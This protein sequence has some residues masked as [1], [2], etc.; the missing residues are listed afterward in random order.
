MLT[1]FRKVT[2]NKHKILAVLDTDSIAVTAKQMWQKK[3]GC[4]LINNKEGKLIGIV[5]ERDIVRALAAGMDIEKTPVAD[6]MTKQVISYPPDTNPRKARE[7]M[8]ANHIRHL[9]IADGDIAM[10]MFSIRDVTQ[11]QILED[12]LAAEKVLMMS[13][14]LKSIDME[15]VIENITTEVPKLFGAQRCVLYLSL[16]PSALKT[17]PFVS[18]KI[19]PCPHEHLEKQI[20][21]P[22]SAD[23]GV[24]LQSDTPQNCR[25]TGAKCPRLLIPL[26]IAGEKKSKN[27][28]GPHQGYLC[29]CSLDVLQAANTDV[30][31]YKVKLVKETLIAHLTNA[32]Q[33]HNARTASLV[34]ELTK[35]GSRKFFEDKLHDECIRAQRYNRP[36]STAIID[37]DNFK[38]INDTL[39]HA[40][41]DE[42]LKK[43]ADCMNKNKRTIDIM[44]RYGGD[45][46][47]IIMPE[48]T[49]SDA[50]KVMERLRT[51]V[52]QIENNNHITIS[53]GIAERLPQDEDSGRQLMQRADLTL[54]EA[55]RAGRNCVKIW[56]KTMPN[57]QNPNNIETRECRQLQGSA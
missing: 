24:F 1:K 55:K 17:G 21:K 9:P 18:R 37:I 15:Q 32:W 56:D 11:H 41:G 42:A 57:L 25:N 4:L 34:D 12:R 10:G 40:A 28:K 48:T 27:K 51:K 8:V 26:S 2:G 19:C 46:F 7:I 31:N 20:N 52:Q 3:I 14:C 54:Y 39:G 43:V 22:E 38:T 5:T 16:K 23:A 49:A 6:I 36:F 13:A 33:Y 44:A 30:L 45:E 50:A 53:C 29:M 47:V 35:T